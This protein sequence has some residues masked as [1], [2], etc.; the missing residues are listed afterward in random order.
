M[1][2]TLKIES[3]EPRLGHLTV[4]GRILLLE[5]L[6]INVFICD[7]FLEYENNYFT[8]YADN[9]KIRI[10]DENTKEVLKNLSALAK[11]NIRR[12]C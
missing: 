4:F 5:S 12:A 10:V 6:L 9:T 2:F 11:S 8:I 7:I 3:K 1:Q